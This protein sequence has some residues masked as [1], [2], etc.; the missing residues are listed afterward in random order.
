MNA[1]VGG[2][3]ALLGG[4]AAL[5][6][7]KILAGRAA[8][9]AASLSDES[10]MLFQKATNFY[11]TGRPR[12]DFKSLVLQRESVRRSEQAAISQAN[13]CARLSTFRQML[14]G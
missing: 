13:N 3:S 1:L 11:K 7:G 8:S 5:G 4:G 2:A 9:T 10:A 14:P 6:V 12:S